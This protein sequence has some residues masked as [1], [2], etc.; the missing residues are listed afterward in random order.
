MLDRL[1]AVEDEFV[2]LEASLSDPDIGADQARLRDVSR[3]YKDLTP[4]VD[5][6]R[7]LRACRADADAARELIALTS[8]EERELMRAELA[9]TET[10]LAELEE[11][12]RLLMLPKDPND[13]RAVIMEIR[14]AEG[15]EEANLFAGDLYDMYRAFAM[16][17]GWSVTVLSE[18]QIGR[19][20]V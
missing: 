6:I 19:A 18:D 15:G 11:E 16:S 2:S 14:G 20:H 12:L 8:D 3:R 7:R 10:R 5:C 9:S 13:G 4:V 17:H 1:Q